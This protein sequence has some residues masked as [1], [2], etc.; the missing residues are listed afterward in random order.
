MY[1]NETDLEARFGK[2]E[3]LIKTENAEAG[4]RVQSESSETRRH[5]DA[6]AEGLCDQIKI[7]AQGHSALTESMVDLKQG[8]ARLE[9]GQSRLELLQLA[10]ESQQTQLEKSQKVLLGVV[11]LLAS[12]GE[13]SRMRRTCGT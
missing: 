1:V 4:R 6:V 5:V 13:R 12:E 10:L 11:R 7:V 3:S 9:A 8:F 2:V